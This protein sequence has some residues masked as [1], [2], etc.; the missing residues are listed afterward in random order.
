MR[1]SVSSIL[2][3][4]A[5]SG[6]LLLAG[7]ALAQSPPH[8][9]PPMDFVNEPAITAQMIVDSFRPAPSQQAVDRDQAMGYLRATKDLLPEKWCAPPGLPNHEVD[10]EVIA[11]LAQ[12]P[13]EARKGAA[14]PLIGK[15]LVAKFPCSK[16]K[17]R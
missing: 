10:G 4:V 1:P 16:R 11:Y 14:A 5:L 15:A 2:A 7:P 9:G 13:A 6:P 8:P 12:L 17:E 3:I